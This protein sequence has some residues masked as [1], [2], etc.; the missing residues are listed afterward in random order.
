[1]GRGYDL[2]GVRKDGTS[3]PV[4]ISLNYYKQGGNLMVMALIMDVTVR[5]EQE[6]Q[7]LLLNK[8]LERRVEK[9]TQELEESQLLYR[10]IARNFPNGTINVFDKSFN[11]VFV[12]GQDL[13]RNGITSER[14]V[15]KNYLNQL[16]AENPRRNSKAT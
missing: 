10:M 2:I 14:L 5:K 16:P 11:Y 15:G 13:Y 7:V 1:M 9:R 4:E 3:V 8:N 6:A 12:E